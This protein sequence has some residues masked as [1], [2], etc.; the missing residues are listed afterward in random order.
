MSI[1]FYDDHHSNSLD[2]V[3]DYNGGD[4]IDAYH[5]VYCILYKVSIINT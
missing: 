1:H 5:T 2:E 3:I 4:I